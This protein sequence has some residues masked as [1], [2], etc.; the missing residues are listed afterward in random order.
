[1]EEFEADHAIIGVFHQD[2]LVGRFLTHRFF[3]GV[4][5]PHRKSLPLGVVN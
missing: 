3:G 2:D 1:M 5:E 4:I